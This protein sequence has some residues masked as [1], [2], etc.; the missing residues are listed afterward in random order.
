MTFNPKIKKIKGKD[1]G[2]TVIM[3]QKSHRS[4]AVTVR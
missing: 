4:S 1:N 3:S 2:G